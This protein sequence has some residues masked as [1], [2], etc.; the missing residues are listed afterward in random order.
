[1][2]CEDGIHFAYDAL[3]RVV[4]VGCKRV[5]S[6]AWWA[7]DGLVRGPARHADVKE[8]AGPLCGRAGRWTEV[9]AGSAP[10]D[11]EVLSAVDAHRGDCRGAGSPGD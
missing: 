1:M 2:Q 10:K 11:M 8:Q 7:W 9:R 4:E 3:V 5:M 6:E